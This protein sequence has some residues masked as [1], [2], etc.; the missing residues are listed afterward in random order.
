MLE[1]KILA[2]WRQ[3]E[4][5]VNGLLTSAGSFSGSERNELALL[6]FSGKVNHVLA[7]AIQFKSALVHRYRSSPPAKYGDFGW[8]FT[9]PSANFD[10]GNVKF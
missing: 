8:R 6:S 9:L 3:S 2:K 7:P 5:W 4:T 10:M 1:H